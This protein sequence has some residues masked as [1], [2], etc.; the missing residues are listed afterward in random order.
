MIIYHKTN[1]ELFSTQVII[2]AKKT[3]VTHGVFVWEK[4][5]ENIDKLEN[6]GDVFIVGATFAGADYNGFFDSREKWKDFIKV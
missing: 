4:H 6:D 5:R 3:G 1:N 2:G